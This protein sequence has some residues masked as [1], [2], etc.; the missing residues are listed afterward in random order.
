M[1]FS[2]KYN[3]STH[4]VVDFSLVV[5]QNKLIF[6]LQWLL[7][8][9]TL[10][11]FCSFFSMMK[12]SV[13]VKERESEWEDHDSRTARSDASE[14]GQEAFEQNII[15]CQFS[16]QV[17]HNVAT[18]YKKFYTCVLYQFFVKF[19]FSPCMFFFFKD[20]FHILFERKKFYAF[21]SFVFDIQRKHFSCIFKTWACVV[22]LNE[23]GS[24]GAWTED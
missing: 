14:K 18:I 9:I 21:P 12:I 8:A 23:Y 15:A 24:N 3:F 22:R 17:H 20:T 10:A 5:T 1:T 13:Y 2:V 7:F 6:H 19:F 16:H 11:D 4:R